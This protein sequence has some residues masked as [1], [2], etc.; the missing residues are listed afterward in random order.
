MPNA[1]MG[2][3]PGRGVNGFEL[4]KEEI[5]RKSMF[6]IFLAGSSL[7][8]QRSYWGFRLSQDDIPFSLSTTQYTSGNGERVE[9]SALRNSRTYGLGTEFFFPLDYDERWIGELAFFYRSSTFFGNPTFT[10]RYA[11]HTSSSDS[12]IEIPSDF[13]YGGM[14]IAI[15]RNLTDSWSSTILRP[16]VGIDFLLGSVLHPDD[17][18]EKYE[19]S[20][21]FLPS[22]LSGD[23][24]FLLGVNGRLHAGIALD[25]RQRFTFVILSPGVSYVWKL[26]DPESNSGWFSYEIS[27]GVFLAM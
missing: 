21:G 15:G 19:G 20:G 16:S 9:I 4:K 6:L 25:G 10:Y 1:A 18:Y 26:N 8:A 13:S 22:I 11:L 2:V 17:A 5:V 23:R 3:P 14:R 27:L 24:R 12:S 7:F